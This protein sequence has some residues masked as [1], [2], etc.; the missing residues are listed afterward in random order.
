VQIDSTIQTRPLKRMTALAF[1]ICAPLAAQSSRGAE[2]VEAVFDLAT[3]S[4]APFPSDRFTVRD[5]TQNTGRRVQLPKPDCSVRRTDCENIEVINETD[6]FNIQPRISIPFNGAIDVASVSSETVFLLEME[7]RAARKEDGKRNERGKKQVSLRKIGIDRVVWDVESKTLHVESADQLDQHTRYL[8][9]VTRGIRDASGTPVARS[10][11]FEGFRRDDEEGSGEDRS[12]DEYREELADALERARDSGIDRDRIAVASVFTTISV[13]ATLEKLRDQVLAMPLPPPADFRLGPMGADG[14]ASRTV[15]ALNQT[16]ACKGPDPRALCGLTFNQESSTTGPLVP[17]SLAAQVGFLRLFPGK[18]GSVAFGKY[19]S[20]NYLVRPVSYVPSFG[21]RTGT[22][23]PQGIED[24][25]FNLFLPGGSPPPGG[26][27]VVIFIH[28]SSQNKNTVP[29]NVAASM[30]EHGLATIAISAASHGFGARSTLTAELTSG[31]KVTFSAGGRSFDQDGDGHIAVDEGSVPSAPRAVARSRHSHLQ[32]VVDLIQLVNT[33]EIGI[34]VDG[35]GTPDL[36]AS[37]IYYA[38]NSGGADTGVIFT[39]VDRRIRA[40]VVTATGAGPE[41]ARLSPVNRPA[42][43]DLFEAR[44]PSILNPPGLSSIG[45]IP[46]GLPRFDENLPLRG[47]GPV[48]NE[49]PGAMEIQQQ[50]ERAEWM[51]QPA[52]PASFA[53]FLR[54][55]PLPGVPPRPII[56]QI[57]RGDESVPNP[58]TAALL[59]AGDLADRA[60]LYRHDLFAGKAQFKNPHTFMLVVG[61]PVMKDISL[62]AQRQIATFFASDGQQVIDPDDSGPLFEVPMRVDLRDLETRLEFVP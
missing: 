13:S 24:V 18:V 11:G 3:M 6:G 2:P 7:T 41:F 47:Q 35:D 17:V 49:V 34:D 28:G 42:I 30:A 9:V 5:E 53:P 60:T 32:T 59:R 48:V 4:T 26:W 62:A 45:G 33:I 37:R 46:V 19:T 29:F 23:Q 16:A 22:P 43:G 50:F 40:A 10:A 25:Y 21:T 27:P 8:L 31:E 52:E 54:K 39:A 58:A 57:A 15:F 61:T 20:P 51:V 14:L 36:D 38:G 55:A 56:I 1:L 12:L 44:I